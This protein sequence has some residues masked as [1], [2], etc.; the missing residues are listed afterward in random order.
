MECKS[1]VFSWLLMLCGRTGVLLSWFADVPL[2]IRYAPSRMQPLTANHPVSAP[3]VGYIKPG[4]YPIASTSAVVRTDPYLPRKPTIA[5]PA[6]SPK[7]I[8][9]HKWELKATKTHVLLLPGIRFKESPYF[10][11]D[12]PVSNVV[13]CPGETVALCEYTII[14]I[15]FAESSSPTDRRQQVLAFT[16][17]PEQIAKLKAPGYVSRLVYTHL[18]RNLIKLQEQVSITPFL[19]FFYILFSFWFSVESRSLSCWVPC[20]LRSPS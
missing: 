18:E 20:D 15:P 5:A 6:P 16:L 4:P 19:H 17:N 14:N 8:G 11:I 9:S 10:R 1:S 3:A 2:T 13:E 7:A 12:Q